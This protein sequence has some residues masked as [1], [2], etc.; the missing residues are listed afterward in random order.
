VKYIEGAVVP[1]YLAYN[2]GTVVINTITGLQ[3]LSK[4]E[5][6]SGMKHMSLVSSKLPF[7]W[8]EMRAFAEEVDSSLKGFSEGM[9]VYTGN[10]LADVIPKKRVKGF[11]LLARGRDAA[12]RFALNGLLGTVDMAIKTITINAAYNQFKAGEAPGWSMDRIMK[13]SPEEVHVQAKAYAAQMSQSTTMSVRELDKAPLQK[14]ELGQIMARFWNEPRNALNNREQDFRNTKYDIKAMIE[15]SQDGDYVGA[16]MAFESALDRSMRVIVM[17]AVSVAIFNL[18]RGRDFGVEEDDIVEDLSAGQ[19]LEQMLYWMAYRT[20]TPGGVA[21][22]FADGVLTNVP[23]VRDLFYTGQTGQAVTFPLTS[24]LT[25]VGRTGHAAYETYQNIQLGLSLAEALESLDNRQRRAVLN[26]TSLALGG[27]P[28][29]G[30]LK[31]YSWY[32]EFMENPPPLD[33]SR[34]REAAVQA[35]DRFIDRF[36]DADAK[37]LEAFEAAL[38]DEGE[39]N[40]EDAVKQA[41]ALRAEILGVRDGA[42]VLTSEEFDL[43][44]FAESSG[45]WRASPPGSSAFG[46]YQFTRGTWEEVMNSPE[47]AIAGLTM[48][49]WTSS[50]PDQQEA[51]MRIFTS[52]NA[53]ALLDVGVSPTLETI[54][55][56]HH[57]GRGAVKKYASHIFTKSENRALPKGFLTASIKAANPALVQRNVRTIGD[58]RKYLQWNLDR[59]RRELE[60]SRR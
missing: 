44:K 54:Y 34:S 22:T 50:N 46:L 25:D 14:I 4:M 53:Q 24:M 57:F 2:L 10:L 16:N 8:N 1:I 9:E 11:S 19:Q 18:A 13:M 33:L 6:K 47:G 20:L 5:F 45:N 38:R 58:F 3:V 43:I 41:K 36:D 49:G 15:K 37:E 60:L 48:S 55:F 26:A 17:T 31:I 40:L 39:S 21:K 12:N 32:E 56:A 23:V 35:L 27:F 29:N 7:K 51:A 52:W 59:G 42:D 30:P 28:V